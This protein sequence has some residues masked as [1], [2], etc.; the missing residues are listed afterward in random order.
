MSF[1]VVP[2]ALSALSFSTERER[3]FYFLSIVAAL[4]TLDFV[5]HS[6]PTGAVL[7]PPCN[8]A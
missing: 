6:L 7:V 2:V 3:T 8:V 5:P 1:D 4:I